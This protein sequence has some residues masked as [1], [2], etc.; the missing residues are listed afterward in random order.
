MLCQAL[1]ITSKPLVNSNWSYN[2]KPLIRVKIGG[3]FFLSRV[4][5]K[6]DGWPW[7]TIGHFFFATSSF[8]HHFVAISEFW[9]CSLTVCELRSAFMYDSKCSTTFPSCTINAP[10]TFAWCTINVPAV[11]AWCTNQ[12]VHKVEFSYIEWNG[13]HT[14][15]LETLNSGENRQFFLSCV[16]LQ[17]CG[18]PWKT[19][20]HLSYAASSVVH[21]LITICEF[22]LELWSGN[23]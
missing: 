20:G 17:F 12:F 18:C 7:K 19:I 4:T 5:L 2:R 9:S 21:R 23:D 1:C 13:V 16:T 6:F 3:V 22:I 8:V 15:S 10:A 14:V 11:F